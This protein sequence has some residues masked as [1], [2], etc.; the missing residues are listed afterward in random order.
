MTVTIVS[1]GWRWTTVRV[2]LPS[3]YFDVVA[4]Q[5]RLSRRRARSA[6]LELLGYPA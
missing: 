5:G 1:R 3:G 4:L 2:S 6:A